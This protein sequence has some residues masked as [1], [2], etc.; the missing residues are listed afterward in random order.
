[1][2]LS[3]LFKINL[4]DL[5]KGI[6]IA[7]ISAILGYLYESLSNGK[8]IRFREIGVVSLT[9]FLG[10]ITNRFFSN[11]KGQYLKKD[12]SENSLNESCNNGAVTREMVFRYG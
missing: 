12:S 10:Y 6:V 7:I 8:I 3:K 1:M 9:S 5:L 2:K 4:L 11:S